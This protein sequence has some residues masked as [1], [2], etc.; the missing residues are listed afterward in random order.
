VLSVDNGVINLL[1][2]G[3]YAGEEVPDASAAGTFA[4]ICRVQKMVNPKLQLDNGDV[5]WGCECWWGGEESVREHVQTLVDKG[6]QLV[7]VRI[8]EARRSLR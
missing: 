8:G 3:V 5:V 4:R 7:E 2:Y 6:H 1:G